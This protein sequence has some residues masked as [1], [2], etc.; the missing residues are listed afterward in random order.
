M[1]CEIAL[2]NYA[3]STMYPKWFSWQVSSS[4]TCVK[5]DDSSDSDD[6]SSDEENEEHNPPVHSTQ[7]VKRAASAHLPRDTKTL[8]QNN[9]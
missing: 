4:G 3:V 2:C 8:K 7:G 6:D 5:A 1:I 9:E